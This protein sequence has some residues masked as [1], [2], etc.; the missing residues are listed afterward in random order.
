M[1]IRHLQYVV[2]ASVLMLSGCSAMPTTWTHPPMAIPYQ[3]SLQQQI[4][5]ARIEQILQQPNIPQTTLATIYYDRGLLHDSLGLRDLA[6]LDFNK[7]LTLNPNQPDL[8]NVAGVIFTQMGLF[9]LAYEAFD[10]TLDLAPEHP[11]AHRNRG[12]ALYYGERYDLANDDLLPHYQQDI[13]DPYRVIWLYINDLKFVPEQAQTLLQQRY[14]ASDKQDWGWQIVRMYLGDIS[15]E[16][17]LT[18]IAEQSK[19]NQQLALRLTEGYFYLA[20]RYQN[21]QDYS[22]AV[23]LYKLALAGNVYE[24][25]EHRLSLLELDRILTAEQNAAPVEPV[26]PSA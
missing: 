2:I 9:D 23:M 8:Y 25:V 20:Q 18:E 10:S 26:P 4:Q 13:N 17:F 24:F 21:Q 14:A 11:Y 7:S 15:E 3:P 22:T 6:R 16:Q 1:I 5:L 19:D 12:I